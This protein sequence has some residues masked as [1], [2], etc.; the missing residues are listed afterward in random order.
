MKKRAG[1]TNVSCYELYIEGYELSFMQNTC[2]PEIRQ[3]FA[4]DSTEVFRG[5]PEL[6]QNVGMV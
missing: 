4:G 5:F 3:K 1:D 2:P 6:S